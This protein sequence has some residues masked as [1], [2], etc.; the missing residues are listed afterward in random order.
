[1]DLTLGY[2][3]ELFP[4][5]IT[6]TDR[7][8]K[9]WPALKSV[10]FGYEAR[11]DA[12]N[13]YVAGLQLEFASRLLSI[14]V[15]G[16]DLQTGGTVSR[17]TYTFKY[18]NTSITKRSLL[19]SI[20]ECD[21]AA[22]CKAPLKFEWE[23]GLNAFHDFDTGYHD[24]SDQPPPLVWHFTSIKAADM[25]GDGLDDLIMGT[26]SSWWYLQNTGAYTGQG[27]RRYFYPTFYLRS[28]TLPGLQGQTSFIDM[29]RNGRA[30]IL[31]YGI[32]C[33]C[34][35]ASSQ[36]G[37]PGGAAAYQ[38]NIFPG[39]GSAANYTE[40]YI[41]GFGPPWGPATLKGYYV[42]DLNGDGYPDLLVAQ[43]DAGGNSNWNY[44]FAPFGNMPDGVIPASAAP[45]NIFA[46]DVDAIGTPW[47]SGT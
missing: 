43:E 27:Q 29:D 23:Q 12:Y 18:A 9:R 7:T 37:C 33:S 1:L 31:T 25:N 16:P 5:H 17:R 2:S 42:A 11:P 15:S 22:V 32:L 28:E 14:T 20:T 36:C 19:T 39:F 6:Y 40:N 24:G 41:Y 35:L 47:L 21:G 10:Q 26:P 44:Y 38:L 46:V 3:V 4:D 34:S 30:D 8:D 13:I 45:Q